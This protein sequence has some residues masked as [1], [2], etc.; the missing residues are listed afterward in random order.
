MFSTLKRIKTDLRSSLSVD[1]LLK[2]SVDGPPLGK[3]DAS[4]AIWLWWKESSEDKSVIPEP[5]QQDLMSVV[6]RLNLMRQGILTW[7]IS[8]HLLIRNLFSHFA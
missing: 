3:W 1:D 4:G 2:I 6:K 5:H 8:K 7:T